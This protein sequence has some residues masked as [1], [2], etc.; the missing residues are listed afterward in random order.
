MIKWYD[1]TRFIRDDPYWLLRGRSVADANEWCR[2]NHHHTRLRNEYDDDGKNASCYCSHSL[3]MMM[4]IMMRRS[5]V[6]LTMMNV[7][8]RWERA[9]WWTSG[10]ANSLTC[11]R[12]QRCNEQQRCGESTISMVSKR[13]RCCRL[14][15]YDL[16]GMTELQP[17]D[18]FLHEKD[19]E[20]CD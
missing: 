12:A 9:R 1:G 2:G 3:T 10:H 15:I 16:C 8:H 5:P 19:A 6:W 18:R 13:K 14:L 4:M 11:S 17:L 20:K 7:H